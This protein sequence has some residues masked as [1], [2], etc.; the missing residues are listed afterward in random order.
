MSKLKKVAKIVGAAV[1]LVAGVGGSYVGVQVSRFNASMERVYD[2]PL[3]A[4]KVTSDAA[5]IARGKHLSES[6][7]GCAL[8][9]CHGSDLGGGPELAVGPLGTFSA[10]NITLIVPSYSDAELSRLLRYGL[11]RDGRSV[12]FMPAQDVAWWREEDRAAL[13]AYLRTVPQVTRPNNLF[14]L[15]A[16]AKVLDRRGLLV[17]DVARRLVGQTIPQPPL[18]ASTKEYGAFVARLCE[19]CHGD[20]LSGGPIPGAPPSLPI[21]V[22]LT[23]HPS[24]LGADYPFEQF[25]R[26]M[27]QGIKK[28]GQKL[29]PFMPVE[30][31]ARMNDTEQHALYAYLRSLPPRP[32]GDR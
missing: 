1:L 24:G 2:V 14:K 17:V 15:G 30:A 5:A 4:V 22:N 23:P 27:T 21:P 9:D 8:R 11:R 10:P 6:M 3:P 26:L 29:D 19:G 12:R 28:N 31:L 18:P 20:H 7:G 25:V 16:L 13:I 32:F